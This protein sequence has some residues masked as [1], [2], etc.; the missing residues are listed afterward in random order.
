MKTLLTCLGCLI[1]LCVCANVH[2]GFQCPDG[3]P[4]PCNPKPT[5]TPAPKPPAPPPTPPPPP[6]CYEANLDVNCGL[7]GCVVSLSGARSSSLTAGQ[8]GRVRFADIPRGRYTVAV[9]KPGYEGNSLTVQLG[10]G[11]EKSVEL[12]LR[13]R[14]MT[15][16]LRTTPPQCEIL[17]DGQTKGQSD[18]QGAFSLQVTDSALKI[19]ARKEGY[20]SMTKG[21]QLE[22]GKSEPEIA[23]TLNPI[24]AM[25]TIS[26]NLDNAQVRVDQ[27]T[28][29]RAVNEEIAL[30]PGRHQLTVEALGHKPVTL[31]VNLAPGA[32]EKRSV[33]LDRLPLAEL[34][35]QAEAAYRSRAYAS[36]LKLCGYMFEADAASPI[37]HRLAGLAR[38]AEQNYRA[39]EPHLARALAGGE[40]ISL[41]VRRHLR[42]NF[43][44]SRGHDVCQAVLV[45]GKTEVEFRGLQI[46]AEDFKVPYSQAQMLRLETRG[47]GD[48]ALALSVKITLAGGRK[49]DYS[50]FSPDKE[51]SLDGKPYLEML[52]RLL[53][54]H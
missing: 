20:L 47:S 38:L 31:E 51:I 6:P 27:Q 28:E 30:P 41:P 36:V 1:T 21:L 4:P 23:L 34:A 18:A 32:K 42:E 46:A 8:E 39:A 52:Q 43:D 13:I 35:Q 54:A 14:P 5:P 48:R 37:A 26:A 29:Q 17:I 10:C 45:L 11:E 19:E 50:F 2:Y 7:P 24:P 40:T 22:P 15:L 16:R 9:S 25:L 3:K 12:R 44:P 49:R 53:Q 33:K